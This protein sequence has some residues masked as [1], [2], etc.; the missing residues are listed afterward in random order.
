M[1]YHFNFL[2]CWRRAKRA[3]RGWV[4]FKNTCFGDVIITVRQGRQRRDA[5]AAGEDQLGRCTAEQS[6]YYRL[7]LKSGGSILAAM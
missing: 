6:K 2:S 7:Y 3:G 5:F 1:L 4:R